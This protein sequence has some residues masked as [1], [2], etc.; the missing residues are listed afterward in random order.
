[1]ILG[2]SLYSR[3]NQLTNF[4]KLL[5]GSAK[6]GIKILKG[7]SSEVVSLPMSGAP[8]LT[9]T[10]DDELRCTSCMLCANICPSFCIK[11]EKPFEASEEVAPEVFDI[12]I[13]KC[14]FCGLCEDAC[15]V[16]AIRMSGPMPRAGH[17]EQNWI[18]DKTHLSTYAGKQVSKVGDNRPL[19]PN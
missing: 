8:A 9:V 10:E 11:I 17:S 12:N 15:P 19:L 3:K 7:K 6:S 13:L 5:A 4:F 1:M 2:K 16:D 14:T 18:W